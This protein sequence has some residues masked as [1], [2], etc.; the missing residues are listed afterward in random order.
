MSIRTDLLA[1]VTTSLAG[2]SVS[3]STEL[4][5]NS[6][7]VPLYEKNMKK[8]YISKPSQ[9][10]TQLH[11]TLDRSDVF[12]TETTLTGYITVDAKNEPSDIDAV[13]ASVLN[14]RNAIDGQYINECLVETET[15]QDRI[16]YTFTYR[17]QKVN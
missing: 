8:F 7:G 9:D 5:W 10:I 3:V 4:P 11:T 14:S 6:G 13:I 12:T 2:T 17:F 16:T 15:D 1:N